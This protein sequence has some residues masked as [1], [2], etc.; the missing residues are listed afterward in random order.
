MSH[1]EWKVEQ[2]LPLLYGSINK[3]LD[4]RVTADAD[5]DSCNTDTH[6]NDNGNTN[7][8]ADNKTILALTM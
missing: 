3:E 6:H 5:E 7:A 8:N 1:V 2:R 4:C